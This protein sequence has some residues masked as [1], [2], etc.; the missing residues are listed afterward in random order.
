MCPSGRFD[1]S[2]NTFACWSTLCI[3]AT[4]SMTCCVLRQTTFLPLLLEHPVH[5][6]SHQCDLLPYAMGWHLSALAE[7][8]EVELPPV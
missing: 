4:T 7:F 5:V 2:T 6:S 8:F 1:L 3:S